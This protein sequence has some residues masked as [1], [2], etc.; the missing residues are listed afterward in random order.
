MTS[1]PTIKAAAIS[2]IDGYNRKI[3]V[4][5][6]NSLS[7]VVYIRAQS[8]YSWG[9]AECADIYNNYPKYTTFNDT[10]SGNPSSLN[11]TTYSCGIGWESCS[12]PDCANLQGPSTQISNVPV[13]PYNINQPEAPVI[14]VTTGDTEATITWNAVTDPTGGE[15][16]AYYFKVINKL[17]IQIITEGYVTVNEKPKTILGVQNG[18]TH[19]VEIYAISQNGIN[20][21]VGSKDF[22]PGT[23]GTPTVTPSVTPT[24]TPKPYHNVC[25]NDNCMEWNTPGTDECTVVGAPCGTTTVTPTVT[26]TVT[27]TPT[28]TPTTTP[29]PPPGNNTTIYL[30]VTVGLLGAGAY[31][32]HT[33]DKNE[34]KHVTENTD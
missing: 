3:Q 33:K 5:Y 2:D 18:I 6:N 25:K 31:Y 34:T 13:K 23:T 19:K 17:T 16:F 9:H 22:I 29:I 28:I 14:D 4:L 10:W 8:P 12:P 1:N 30:L 20:G 27:V 15:V 7:G 24:A 32:L 26:P 21:P 11:V